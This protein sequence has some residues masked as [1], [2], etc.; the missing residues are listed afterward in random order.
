MLR[1]LL[2]LILMAAVDVGESAAGSD[3]AGGSCC[4]RC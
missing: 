4:W 2:S 1:L 3:D